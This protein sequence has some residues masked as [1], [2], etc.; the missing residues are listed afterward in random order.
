M[1]TT[2]LNVV[3]LIDRNRVGALQVLVL[4]LCTLCQIID[5]FDV[6]AIGYV[7][8]AIIKSWGVAKADLGPVFGAGLVGMT[9]GALA[10]SPMADRLGRRP[11]LA[12]AMA[13]IAICMYATSLATTITELLLLRLATGLGMGAMIPVAVAMAGEFSPARMRVTLMMMT[14][15]GFIVGGAIGGAIAAWLIPAFGWQS[16]FVAGAVAP[17]ALAVLILLLMPESPQFMAFKQRSATQIAR[18]LKRIDPALGAETEYQFVT[19][20]KK[21]HGARLLQLFHNGLGTG[22]VLLWTVNFMNLLAA[23]FLAN[24]LPVLM[25]DAGHGPSQAILAG[26]IFWVGGIAGNLLIGWFADHKGFGPTLTLVFIAAALAM[27]LIGQV[28]SSLVLVFIVIAA[29]GFCVLGGQTALNALGA[30]YYPISVRSTGMG[31]AMGIG[32]LGA[33]F[34]PVV[35]GE[36]IRLNWAASDLF[37]AAAVPLAL[38]LCTTLAFWWQGSLPRRAVA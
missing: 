5:G 32:R 12:G 9:I 1:N 38:A 24:W 19:P 15:S 11:M 13:F 3:D 31:W 20:E 37:L 27:M 28:A 23:Y 14:S 2:T 7:A 36:L 16:V 21:A 34:G 33:I 6:Q 29:A 25:N 35:G 22:T 26:T 8:P 4:A 10:V 18:I 30:V 17:L